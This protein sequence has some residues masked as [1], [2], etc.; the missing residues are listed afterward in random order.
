MPHGYA[1]R[2]TKAWLPDIRDPKN[3]G[4]IEV[5]N[6]VPTVNGL[7]GVP[8]YQ[9]DF[10]NAIGRGEVVTGAFWGRDPYGSPLSIIATRFVDEHGTAKTR[11]RGLREKTWADLTPDP[12]PDHGDGAWTFLQIGTTVITVNNSKPYRLDLEPFYSP[13]TVDTTLS[14]RTFTFGSRAIETGAAI[15]V[16]LSE[17]ILAGG[18]FGYTTNVARGGIVTLSVSS[19]KI[20][21]MEAVAVG[22]TTVTVTAKDEAGRS[23]SVT[24]TV[25]VPNQRPIPTQAPDQNLVVGTPATLDLSDYFRD[26]AGDVLAFTATSTNENIVTESV[27]GSVLTLTPVAAGVAS[28]GV[29]CRDQ[30]GQVAAMSIG[31]RVA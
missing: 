9:D 15:I 22:E 24:F 25:I 23:N 26:T 5:A 28:V 29:V 14:D 3:P 13:V 17:Y 1:V 18:D 8:G 16:R 31:V 30:G 20:M 10:T 19:D 2:N 21:R 11:F 4:F 7:G 27:A 6:A 12:P